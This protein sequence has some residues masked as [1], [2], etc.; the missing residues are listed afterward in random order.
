[1]LR[2]IDLLEAIIRMRTFYDK[3][4]TFPRKT[5]KNLVKLHGFWFIFRE[6]AIKVDFYDCFCTNFFQYPL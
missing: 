2:N 4:V 1:M 3:I 5:F 6:K